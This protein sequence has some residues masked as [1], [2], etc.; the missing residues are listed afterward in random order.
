MS[1]RKLAVL[2]FMTLDGVV[3]A[4]KSPDEDT[5]DNFD[6]GGWAD[7]PYWDEV[8][9]SVGAHAM[10]KPYDLLLGRKT[11][12]LFSEFNA[13]NP[14]SPLNDLTKY[15]VTNTLK[16]LGWKNSIPITGNVVEQ[17]TKLKEREG[18]LLQVHGSWE[19]IQMLLKHDLVDEFRLWTFPVV[20]G[21]GK[22]LFSN[23]SFHKNLRLM[24]SETTP[25][26][27]VMGIYKKV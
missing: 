14:S 18:L 21:K 3:Q 12:S 4:P 9:A 26:G 25:N 20:L 16:E 15:V 11:Y 10:D 6:L 8:M 2:T 27:V 5:S 1:K 23:R 22:R 19:L 24:K 13:P 17:I 7:N